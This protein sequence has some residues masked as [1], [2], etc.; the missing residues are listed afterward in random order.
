MPP[1]RAL[2]RGR[3]FV[4]QYYDDT[5]FG[6]GAS[7]PEMEPADISG[8]GTLAYASGDYR[9]NLVP[10]TADRNGATAASFSGCSARTTACG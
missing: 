8:Q 3:Q 6:E 4:Q 2:M 7:D 5:R 9:L 1:N 10:R